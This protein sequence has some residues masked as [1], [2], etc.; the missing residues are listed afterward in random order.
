MNLR[1]M[2]IFIEEDE[3]TGTK[4]KIW[5]PINH[6]EIHF[7]RFEKNMSKEKLLNDIKEYS[8]QYDLT[9]EESYVTFG[10]CIENGYDFD[11]AKQ[12]IQAQASW[13]EVQHHQNVIDRS[14]EVIDAMREECPH[15]PYFRSKKNGSNTGNWC[16]QDD[17]YW[18]DY[19]CAACGKQWT[20]Y[21]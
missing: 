16:P 11:D 13:K 15:P 9:D 6:F 21:K 3:S 17:T 4:G 14:Q 8:K 1:Y 12:I 7:E 19:S 20:V 5:C 2:N 18:V 10:I